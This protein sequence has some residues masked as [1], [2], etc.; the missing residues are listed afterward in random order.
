MTKREPL[1]DEREPLPQPAPCSFLR[2]GQVFSGS[3]RVTHWTPG[4]AEQWQVSVKLHS[5]S[6]TT[7]EICGTM[8][9]QDVPEAEA[10]V[11]TFFQGEIIDNVNNSFYTSHT[12][13]AALAETDIR[14][15][16]RFPA[17]HK[18]RKD[19]EK[20]GGRAPGLSDCGVVFMRWK[21]EFFV[22]GG[23]CRLT[24]AG[25]YYCCLDRA[26]G[27][28]QALYFD[29]ASSPDQR[30]ELQPCPGGEAGFAFPA[31]ELA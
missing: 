28:I 13:W 3:Q 10:P 21:E 26:T 1:P 27:D 31:H 2:P 8:T 12:D 16:A 4:K 5:Y 15:W 19:V 29:P 23:E 30:L 14:H 24:I 11:V 22:T 18:I 20:Y 6:H 25:F 7:G 9:A 17:Y